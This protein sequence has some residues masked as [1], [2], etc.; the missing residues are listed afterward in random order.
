VHTLLPFISS[1]DKE[2]LLGDCA[3]MAPLL[4]T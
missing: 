2:Y 1:D 4:Q 3:Y